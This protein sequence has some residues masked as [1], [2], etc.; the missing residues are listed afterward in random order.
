MHGALPED[1]AVLAKL[2]E[3]F[4]QREESFAEQNAKRLRLV[5]E[6]FTTDAFETKVNI[7]DM[8]MQPLDAM[9]NKFLQRSAMLRQ[10]RFRETNGKETMSE[11]KQKLQTGFF[12]WA[13]G[14]MGRDAI[15]TFLTNLQSLELVEYCRDMSRDAAAEMSMTCFRL[16]IFSITDIWRRCCLAT[17]CFP[18]RM[19][20]LTNCNEAACR[21]KWAEFR[22]ILHDCCECVDAAFGAPLLRSADVNELQGGDRANFVAGV[23]QMLCDIATFCPL[24]SDTVENLHGQNQN[25]LHAWRGSSKGHAAAGETSVLSALTSEHMHL[26]SL[27]YGET[28]PSKKWLDCMQK[29]TGRNK[30]AGNTP[31]PSTKQRLKAAAD[32]KPR[33]L[34]PWNVFRRE[35]CKEFGRKMSRAEFD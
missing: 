8:L 25:N 7:A 33:R 20:D 15:R 2:V 31:L 17:D 6:A 23:Q 9:M 21:A 24:G 27:V 32:S 13:T 3:D 12:Q 10:L 35:K 34:S 14:T 5:A 4:M 16:S 1:P 28:M 29:N 22:Q 11:L 30:K 26:E 18:W 19:W